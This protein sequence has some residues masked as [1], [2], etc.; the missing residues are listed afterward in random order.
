MW[1]NDRRVRDWEEAYM[2]EAR[3]LNAQQQQHAVN[4]RSQDGMKKHQ[5]ADKARED[6]SKAEFAPRNTTASEPIE[7]QSGKPRLRDLPWIALVDTYPYCC[8]CEKWIQGKQLHGDESARD[9]WSNMHKSRMDYYKQDGEFRKSVH[10][11]VVAKTTKV[12]TAETS[13]SKTGDGTTTTESRAGKR[14]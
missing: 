1:R 3:V 11:M 10:E 6:T 9:G 2:A 12:D 5:S 14:E 4:T 7:P 13:R 8:A